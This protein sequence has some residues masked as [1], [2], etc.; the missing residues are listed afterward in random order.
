MDN[1]DQVNSKP[2]ISIDERL[3]RLLAGQERLQ[4]QLEQINKRL[5]MLEASQ[6]PLHRSGLVLAMVADDANGGWPEVPITAQAVAAAAAAVASVDAVTVVNLNTLVDAP[7]V[8]ALLPVVEEVRIEGAEVLPEIDQTLEQIE[9]TMASIEQVTVSL[10]PV[11][12]K[13]PL[14]QTLMNDASAAVDKT[15]GDL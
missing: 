1:P 15:L 7:P 2:K 5:S 9:L 3:K 10:E 13:V 8:P 6:G 12:L 11:P 4:K 14:I